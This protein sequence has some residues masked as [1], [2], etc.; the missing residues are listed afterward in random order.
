MESDKQPGNSLDIQE[1]TS[2]SLLRIFCLQT[3]YS[4][5]TISDNQVTL[6][7]GQELPENSF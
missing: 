5:L 1:Q 4:S 7:E 3:S 6:I 2:S